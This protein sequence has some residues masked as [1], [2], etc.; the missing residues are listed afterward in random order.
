MTYIEALTELAE[1]LPKSWGARM[2]TALFDG[3]PALHCKPLGSMLSMLPDASDEDDEHLTVTM[4]LIKLM[5][6]CEIV[7]HD[8]KWSAS[9]R[10]EWFVGIADTITEAVVRLAVKVL[11]ARKE[12][13]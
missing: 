2:V 5:G 6:G 3:G 10:E 9:K 13:A 12:E 8:E 4:S 11:R 1:L 7:Q